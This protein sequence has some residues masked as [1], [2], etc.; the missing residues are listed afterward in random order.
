MKKTC[1]VVCILIL[2]SLT[3]LLQA[4]VKVNVTSSKLDLNNPDQYLEA[5]M[6]TR[7]SLDG[8]P[9]VYYW[10]GE[11]YSFVPG[12]EKKRLFHFE[13]FNIGK[14]N[15]V[16]DGYELLTREAAFYEDPKTGDILETWNNPFTQQDVNVV[17]VWNDPV[18]QDMS[19]P[20]EYKSYLKKFLPSEDLGDM[21]AFYL[22]IFPYYESPLP[23]A[24]YP[25]YSQNDTYQAAELFQF[26]VK[27]SD[28]L[29]LKT[30]SAPAY[31]SWTRFSPWMP[32]MEMSDAPGN[33]MFAC[34]GKKLENGFADLP[35][36]IKEYVKA[37]HPEYMN[38]PDT[39]TEP[40]E[41]SWT[42]F[43]KLLD[44]K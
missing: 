42:Y 19:F 11:V 31:I 30:V 44:K 22:D 40:N 29:N 33:L 16:Q 43:K 32:F 25:K 7:G 9:V 13:G 4:G 14:V 15:K 26:F 24:E 38:P 10:S 27:K 34:R 8:T 23:R 20:P 12:E 36:K 2:F 18:N 21:I 41:T 37:K 28:L 3:S 6:K 1:F 39:F 17:H 5:F 35:F